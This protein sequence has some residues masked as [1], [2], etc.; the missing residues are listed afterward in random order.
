MNRRL[1]L[2]ALAFCACSQAA[3]PAEYLVTLAPGA[4]EK[5]LCEV[6]GRF[7]IK[8]VKPLPNNVFVVTMRDDPGL[9][10]MEK[11]RQGNELV[12]AVQRNQRYRRY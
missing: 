11:A 6:Y 3:E 4:D 8:S 7:G 2:A 1:A 5:T 12:K 9:A 10:A